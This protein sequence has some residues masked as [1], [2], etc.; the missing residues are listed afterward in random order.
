MV[1]SLKI[2]Y[3]DVLFLFIE[4]VLPQNGLKNK[5]RIPNKILLRKNDKVIF[6]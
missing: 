5:I 2:M 6:K 4:A 1:F 3:F